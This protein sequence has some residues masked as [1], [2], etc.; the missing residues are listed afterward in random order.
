L[1]HQYRC[2]EKRL[3]ILP[4]YHAMKNAYLYY[5]VT[6]SMA[7]IALSA[8]PVHASESVALDFSLAPS[9]SNTPD[10]SSSQMDKDEP[11]AIPSNGKTA[12]LGSSDQD[13][14]HT[15]LPPPPPTQNRTVAEQ[16]ASIAR[17]EAETT[18]DVVPDAVPHAPVAQTP[19]ETTPARE[20]L[21]FE[22]FELDSISHLPLF[23]ETPQDEAVAPNS[24]DR[25]DGY[26]QTSMQGL[27][28]LFSGGPNSLVARAIG[29]AEGTRTPEGGRTRAYRGHTDPGNGRWNL[30]TFSYQHGANSPDEADE[31]QL[32]RLQGQAE[33][34]MQQASQAGIQ[35]NTA[36]QLN[37]LDLANQS[38]RAALNPGGY[39][40]RLKEAREM[41]L[42]DSEAILWAR[43][44]SFLDPDT[45]KW[46]APGLGNTVQGITADQE[47]RLRAI[48]RAMDTQP[49][50]ED[51]P[52]PLTNEPSA[53]SSGA[54]PEDEERQ[55][56][57]EDNADQIVN[58]DLTSSQTNTVGTYALRAA[59]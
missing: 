2:I 49:G 21:E 36:E 44:R 48:A 47:R 40:D 41:G 11:L 33:T 12:P 53:L 42:R 3:K 54:A 5:L 16:P 4:A 17:L 6:M 58:F 22:P 27:D 45:N 29:T 39:V 59:S 25:S 7:A 26:A 56:L 10:R 50:I 55:L 24:S 57:E 18:A 35:L 19:T 32:A 20:E 13:K 8:A 37:G 52:A 51:R 31:K 30:G 14:A 34:L 1:G 38:P 46:N 9:R 15:Q 28:A 23:Q 43:T